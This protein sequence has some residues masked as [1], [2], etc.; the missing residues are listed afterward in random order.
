LTD[1]NLDPYRN[2][3]TYFTGKSPAGSMNAQGT[4]APVDISLTIC[5]MAGM[6]QGLMDEHIQMGC[7]YPSV[8][9]EHLLHLQDRR[10]EIVVAFETDKQQPGAGTPRNRSQPI[11]LAQHA[12][13]HPHPVRGHL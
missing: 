1:G 9:T 4:S 6:L 3:A 8:K 2:S 11:H 5:R 7:K 13:V 10:Q 12:D